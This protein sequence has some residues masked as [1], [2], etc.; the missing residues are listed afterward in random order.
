MSYSVSIIADLIVLCLHFAE[1]APYISQSH[2]R[3]R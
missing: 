2:E 1:R 3:G